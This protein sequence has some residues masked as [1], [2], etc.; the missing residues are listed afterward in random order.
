MTQLD[1]LVEFHGDGPLIERAKAALARIIEIPE[2]ESKIREG[3]ELH[4]CKLLIMATD[5]GKGFTYNHHRHRIDIS[6][7]K[8]EFL[9]TNRNRY[10]PSMETGL[11]HEI[12]HSRDPELNF[13]VCKA[14][15]DRTDQVMEDASMA[16]FMEVAAEYKQRIMA[17]HDETALRDLFSKIYDNHLEMI[18]LNA[19]AD[20]PQI[21]AYHDRFEKP[22]I[23]LE[24]LV[25]QEL[26]H[27]IR[28]DD[29]I[30]SAKTLGAD[31]K[32]LFIDNVIIGMNE[33]RA[34]RK[35]QIT[36]ADPSVVR[37]DAPAVDGTW[38]KKQ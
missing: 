3:N 23:A 2:I 33:S 11:A 14:I 18:M 10:F 30:E 9:D 38:E 6:D 16:G 27:P 20:D 28:M 7:D 22:A 35:A 17:A 15:V 13:E 31:F 1:E 36:P 21:R 37:P 5:D 29:Y 34:E 12:E 26:G 8:V 4:Q 32:R 19:V 25:A 24:N